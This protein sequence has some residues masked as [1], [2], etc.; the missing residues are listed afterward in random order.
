MRKKTPWAKIIRCWEDTG[1]NYLVGRFDTHFSIE[2]RDSKSLKF[3]K[4]KALPS[5]RTEYLTHLSLKNLQLSPKSL[6]KCLRKSTRLVSVRLERV[7]VPYGGKESDDP[8]TD[9]EVPLMLPNLKEFYFEEVTKHDPFESVREVNFFLDELNLKP[10]LFFGLNSK[11]SWDA[12]IYIHVKMRNVNILKMLPD[13]TSDESASESEDSSTQPQYI[14]MLRRRPVEFGG[15]INPPFCPRVSLYEV[16]VPKEPF[17]QDLTH[18]VLYRCRINNFD[19]LLQ[20]C[21]NL[22]RVSLYGEFESKIAASQINI[23][24]LTR[25]RISLRELSLGYIK[26][27]LPK[28]NRKDERLTL[29]FLCLDCCFIASNSCENSDCNPE[30]QITDFIE[31]VEKVNII[32]CSPELIISITGNGTINNLNCDSISIYDFSWSGIEED[33]NVL[34]ELE[35]S[36]RKALKS[37]EK[38]FTLN[39]IEKN[40]TSF[41]KATKSSVDLSTLVFKYFHWNIFCDLVNRSSW[42]DLPLKKCDEAVNDSDDIGP[43]RQLFRQQWNF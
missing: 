9:F 29:D 28:E 43:P 38:N 19:A 4:F 31:S 6:L 23:E 24:S 20:A 41:W 3:S 21:T 42:F 18:L 15:F 39:W 13:P 32:S 27:V 34:A 36:I 26:I 12:G 14:S 11:M 35:K 30:M 22:V 33:G 5:H 40:D 25:S 1:N 8:S 37:S 2:G 16:Y 17:P 7:K 10:M